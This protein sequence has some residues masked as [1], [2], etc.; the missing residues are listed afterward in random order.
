MLNNPAFVHNKSGAGILRGTGLSQASRS[1]DPERTRR[2]CVAVSIEMVV[3][4]EKD[5][6]KQKA[7]RWAEQ[8]IEFVCSKVTICNKQTW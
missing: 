5:R 1:D 8:R 3:N 4:R 2:A 6:M 7:E